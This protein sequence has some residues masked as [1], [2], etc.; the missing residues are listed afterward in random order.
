MSK[1]RARNFN[2]GLIILQDYLMVYWCV[3][4]TTSSL[5]LQQ[6]LINRTKRKI[7][8]VVRWQDVLLTWIH[9]YGISSFETCITKSRFQL[10]FF[11]WLYRLSRKSFG[12]PWRRVFFLLLSFSFVV[13]YIICGVLNFFALL[14]YNFW[15]YDGTT[16]N[17]ND[18][19][20]INKGDG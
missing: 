14:W 19:I 5:Y 15:W 12:T 11:N 16:Y 18:N 10:H 7:D 9:R 4:S 20:D 1:K 6:T 13:Y 2:V 17:D 8:F 3:K